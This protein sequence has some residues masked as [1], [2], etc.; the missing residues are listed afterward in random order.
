MAY[1]EKRGKSYR[2][3]VSCGYTREG[4]QITRSTTWTPPAGLN[5]RQVKKELDR[6][7]YEF[8]TRVDGGR[9]GDDGIRLAEYAEKYMQTAATRL[10]PVTLRTYRSQLD[11][12][13]LPALG[14][15]RMRDLRT[16]M[17]QDCVRRLSTRG[18]RRDSG[19]KGTT[20]KTYLIVLR[21]ILAQAVREGVIE[22][23]PA[24]NGRIVYPSQ[25]AAEVRI[26][27][28]EELA[29]IVEKLEDEDPGDRLLVHLAIAT[30][31]RAGELSGLRWEDV[32]FS[33]GV[34]SVCRSVYA[35]DGSEAKYKD[36]KTAGSRRKIAL[37]PYVVEMLRQWYETQLQDII[38]MGG[39]WQDA[40]VLLSYKN[41]RIRPPAYISAWW[42]NFL[43]RNGLPH[44]KFH[45]LRHT[46]ATL[47]L[48]AGANIKSVAARLGHTSI[49][50][51]NRY[52]HYVEEADRAAADAL[53]KIAEED[54]QVNIG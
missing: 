26:L 10:S 17:I 36:P 32:D 54:L 2:I 12:C 7:V 30:G 35:A 6:A 5:A 38:F 25:R 13:I 53:E 31:C 16:S 4:R 24:A 44:V 48:S 37:P 34:I 49:T 52:L 23:N 51:T 40:G 19:V 20:V 22:E 46:S 27:T 41:G 3:R 18:G 39:I 50:T 1:I 42:R 43:K 15:V 14:H 9:A 45:S 11:A 28:R 33:E 29:E 21:A 8:E 47:L